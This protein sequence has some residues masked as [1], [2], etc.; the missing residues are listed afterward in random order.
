MTALTKMLGNVAETSEQCLRHH[1]V[2]GGLTQS[3]LYTNFY[4]TQ[5]YDHCSRTCMFF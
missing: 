5:N 3:K 2:R 1:A 4:L